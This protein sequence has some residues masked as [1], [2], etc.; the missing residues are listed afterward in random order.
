M[1]SGGGGG[2]REEGMGDELTV[3]VEAAVEGEDGGGR[4]LSCKHI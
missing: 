4:D 1:V 2:G 3:D